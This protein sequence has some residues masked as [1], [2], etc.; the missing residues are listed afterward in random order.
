MRFLQRAPVQ[1]R[2]TT[3]ST[4]SREPWPCG[5]AP[6][7]SPPPRAPSCDTFAKLTPTVPYS[8]FIKSSIIVCQPIGDILNITANMTSTYPTRC[9]VGKTKRCV[10]IHRLTSP[11]HC[12]N[13]SL[14]NS[15][16]SKGYVMLWKHSSNVTRS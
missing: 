16:H 2:P 4:T 3:S 1:D 10:L 8:G 7:I 9:T 13:V 6:S 11:Q 12:R 15:Y 14:P 5:S